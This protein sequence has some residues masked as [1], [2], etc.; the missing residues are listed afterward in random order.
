LRAR[1]W[2]EYNFEKNRTQEKILKFLI[3]EKETKRWKRI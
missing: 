3:A 1:S 2:R